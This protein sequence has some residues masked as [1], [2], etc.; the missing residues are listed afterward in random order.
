MKNAFKIFQKNGTNKI[1]LSF[2]ML[3][4]RNDV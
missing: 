2:K 1:V 4:K 3:Q